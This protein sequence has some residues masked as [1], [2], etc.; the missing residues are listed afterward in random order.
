MDGKF[1]R[2]YKGRARFIMGM[3]INRLENNVKLDEID[4]KMLRILL[5]ESRTSFTTIANECKITVAAVRMRYKHLWKTGV[6]NGEKMLIN[7]HCLG[8]R[9]IIDLGIVNNFTKQAEVAKFLESK[10][11]ISEVVGPLGKYNFYGKAVL[12]DLNNLRPL[13][14]ELETNP[15]IQQ[16]DAL[17]WVEAVN[18]EHPEN[19]IIK[20]LPYE[21][22]DNKSTFVNSCDEP[23]SIVEIDEND[24][25][26]AKI[27][28]E[29]SRTTFLKI[30]ETLDLSPK[31]IVN[32]YS[33]LR[34]NLLAR[35]TITVNLSKI[36]YKALANLYIKV[37]N[38]C[39]FSV[40]CS[41]L[42]EIPNLIV[43]IKLIGSYDLY[44]AIALEDFDKLFEADEKVRRINGI[45]ATTVY[46]TKMAP[47]WPLNLFPSLLEND[48]LQPKFWHTPET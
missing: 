33:K 5:T 17:I 20:P 28:S 6:I 40:V 27:L 48:S 30:S 46:I 47:S 18:V 26:L 31:T 29:N 32:R 19:L 1:H 9:H 36:G 2:I 8:Y 39:K 22:K 10:P 37:S 42:L 13:I 7:P 4:A 38:Q 34:K 24:R 45:E 43:L 35:S 15:D 12:K 25:K 23:L 3:G 11:F 16:V 41:Q 14:E 44:A 21:K